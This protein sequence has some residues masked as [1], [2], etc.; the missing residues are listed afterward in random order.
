MAQRKELKISGPGWI[1]WLDRTASW[2]NDRLYLPAEV[3]LANMPINPPTVGWN[4]MYQAQGIPCSIPA[5]VEEYFAQ[6]DPVWVYQGVAWFWKKVHIPTEWRDKIVQLRFDETRLRAEVY[7]N[8]RLAAYDLVAET[9]WNREVTRFL[10]FG[11]ENVIAIRITNPGGQ[12][13]WEDFY[14]IQWGNYIFP[15]SHDFGGIGGEIMLT[16]TD[17]VYFD[18]LFVQNL[19][20]AGAR[21]LQIHAAIQNQTQLPA[22]LKITVEIREV[23]SGNS[24]CQATFDQ[25]VPTGISDFS[26]AL[27]VPQAKLWNVD[28][29]N[30][31]HCTISLQGTVGQDHLTT[32]FGFRVFEAKAVG[33]QH[34][35]YFNGK[36]IRHKSAIDWGYYAG[37]GLYATPAM[38]RQSVQAAKDIGHNGINFHRCIGEPLVFKY[39]DELG[40]Y[41]YEEPGG[42]HAG[43][44]GDIVADGTFAGKIMTEKCRRMARRDRNHPSLIMHCLCNEDNVFSPLREK[45][46]QLIHTINP[47]VLVINSSGGDLFNI[48]QQAPANMIKHIRPY[49]NEIREDYEDNHT[50]EDYKG[51]FWEPYLHVHAYRTNNLQYWGEVHDYPGPDN[52]YAAFEM[53]KNQSNWDR[54]F[55]K[56]LH[57]KI[58]EYFH[59]HDLPASSRGVIQTPADVTRQ[60]GR[61]LMYINGRAVQN[62]LTRNSVDGL[63]VNGWSGISQVAWGPGKG[64][65]WASALTDAA[66]NLKG[67]AADYAYWTRDLQI[68]IQRLNGKQF[69]PGEVA[70]FKV[71]LINENRLEAG[72]YHLEIKIIDGKGQYTSEKIQMPVEVQGGDTYTQH[73]DTISLLLRDWNAGYITLEGKLYRDQRVVADGKE[74]ILLKNRVSFNESLARLNGAVYQWEAAKKALIEAKIQPADFTPELAPLSYICARQVPAE[75]ALSDLLRRVKQDGTSLILYFNSEWADILYQKKLFTELP[76]ISACKIEGT[77]GGNG[78]GYLDYD[79]GDQAV[80]G[81]SAIGTNSW[82][83]GE[84]SISPVHRPRGFWPFK[85]QP[86]E[87]KSRAYG[88][89]FAR[90]DLLLVLL[91]EIQYGKGKILL[92][93]AYP[94]DNDDAFSDLL[95]YQLISRSASVAGQPIRQTAVPFNDTTASI[96]GTIYAAKYDL[97][98]EGVA[99]HDVDAVN[100]GQEYRFDGVDIATAINIT[101]VGWVA[102]GE[103]LLYSVDVKKAGLYQVTF[104]YAAP[105]ASALELEFDGVNRRGNIELPATG[106]WYAFRMLETK[107]RLNAGRQK[108][109]LKINQAGFNIAAIHFRIAD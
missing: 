34:N 15:P 101:F 51:I 30:L 7:I 66:R 33:G 98:G 43:Q 58:S 81:Q 92:N 25:L 75:P 86:P 2:V 5:T 36:R 71:S 97:G 26:Q 44:Q 65:Y 53:L 1:V 38:A 16:A 72:A 62:I 29:P 77:W 12:R 37:T 6:G 10:N 89:F 60:A 99:F 50:V 57:A 76:Q 88:A 8:Q 93:P 69:S 59:Q 83:L 48:F 84:I 11:Q 45:V 39:A 96:P 56:P 35:F 46:M 100:H 3:D 107:M 68:V 102:T 54:Q 63:A 42:F 79:L 78:W 103:W 105:Q 18:D 104:H 85:T 95:F 23:P 52:W 28:T 90:P 31:Y 17:P 87:C 9:P 74:Q 14:N 73:L 41:L 27:S 106:D 80:P 21:K 40:L 24:I 32:R 91:G 22:N 82:E 47:T 20:P 108:M 4:T 70:R 49:Q 94:V 55:F 67:P 109:R 64:G 61:S 13:G 19:L